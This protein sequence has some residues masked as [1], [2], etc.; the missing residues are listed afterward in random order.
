[1]RMCVDGRP[2]HLLVW[3]LDGKL[4]LNCHDDLDG[5]Q[6]VESE[7][8]GEVRAGL[9]LLDRQIVGVEEEGT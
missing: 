5:V 6:A 9:E 3:D 8:L 4:L 7:I 1:M 2:S